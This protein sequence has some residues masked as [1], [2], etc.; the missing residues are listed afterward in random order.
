[1]RPMD[2]D[3][4][5]SYAYIA[6]PRAEAVT[7]GMAVFAGMGTSTSKPVGRACNSGGWSKREWK[8]I[9]NPPISLRHWDVLMSPD[10]LILLP[11]CSELASTPIM[12]IT[13]LIL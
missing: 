4:R 12:T 10:V 7:A 11:W 13:D 2:E 3:C 8:R 5:T 6:P 1:M 9:Y